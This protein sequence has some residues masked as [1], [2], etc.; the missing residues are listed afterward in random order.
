MSKEQP[1]QWKKL[2]LI[3]KINQYERLLWRKIQ[4]WHILGKCSPLIYIETSQMTCTENQLTGLV[5]MW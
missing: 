5:S 4:T 1:N 2:I 3:W